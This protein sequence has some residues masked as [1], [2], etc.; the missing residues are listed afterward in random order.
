MAAIKRYLIK[1][2]SSPAKFKERASDIV[3]T[4]D[5]KEHDDNTTEIDDNFEERPSPL[6]V[7]GIAV[8]PT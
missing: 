4:N 3:K 6:T 2:K 7:E 8:F 1:V 5:D